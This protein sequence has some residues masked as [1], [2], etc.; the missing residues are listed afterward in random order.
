MNEATSLQPLKLVAANPRL[1]DTPEWPTP[2]D[3][4]LDE[5]AFGCGGLVAL[6]YVGTDDDTAKSCSVK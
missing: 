5:A 1:A 6:L 4:V 3:S 2:H